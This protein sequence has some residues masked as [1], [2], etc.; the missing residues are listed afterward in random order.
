M[1]EVALAVTGAGGRIGRLLA[2]AW[3]DRDV[4]FL[5]RKDWNILSSDPP[6]FRP[7]VVLDLAG[8]LRGDVSEN[9]H[10][11]ARVA[12]WAADHDARLFYLSSAAVYPG[13]PEPMRE[14]T[15]PAPASDYGR[16]KVIAEAA[17][18]TV[19]P[20]ATCLRLANLAGADS[21]LGGFRPETQV[22]L[23]PVP[24]QAGGPIRSYI[25]PVTLVHVLEQLVKV[26]QDDNPLPDCL[27]I[28]QSGPVAMADLL[29]AAG[30]SWRFGSPRAAVLARMEL[31]ID[32]LASI[33]DVPPAS[34]E[35]LWRELF[36]L[37][38]WP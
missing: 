18:R 11:A 19:L 35:Q 8:V 27:N 9:Q 13:G 28:A 17:L 21:L 26:A 33:V 29:I 15:T 22:L 30:A 16:S 4:I 5:T 37:K 20:S 1:A 6:Q 3:H 10:L 23:D 34:P 7:R 2:R 12:T 14:E 36:S 38:G 25:G 24:E 32:R 31:A